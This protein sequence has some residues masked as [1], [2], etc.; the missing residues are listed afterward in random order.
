MKKIIG[1]IIGM[2]WFL[3][4]CPAPEEK[5]YSFTEPLVVKVNFKVDGVCMTPIPIR[6]MSNYSSSNTLINDGHQ[7]IHIGDPGLGRYPERRIMITRSAR[8]E[9]ISSM[10]P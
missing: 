1:C 3:P 10:T 4:G 9:N 7:F 5:Y 2:C 8:A 6:A